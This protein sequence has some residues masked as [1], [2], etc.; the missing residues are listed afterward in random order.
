MSEE[1]LNLVERIKDVLVP[2]I[3]PI[4]KIRIGSDADGGYVIADLPVDECYSYGSNDEISFEVAMYEKYGC[5]SWTY[6]HT[7][8]GITNKPDYITFKKE[9]ISS[10]KTNDCNTLKSHLKENKSKGMLML[11]MDIEF[12]EWDVLYNINDGVLDLFDQIVIELHFF[13]L[14]MEM[15]DVIKKLQNNFTIIHLH[16]N[17]H[18]TS[19]FLD[20]ELPRVLELTLLNNRFWTTEK[21]KDTISQFPDPNLDARYEIMFNQ[22]MWWR[23]PPGLST[24][25][26]MQHSK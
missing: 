20:W 24:R 7:I 2:H 3:S 25:K 12:S 10:I 14:H 13:K 26:I 11:K 21:V 5:K 6:D 9:G 18:Q 17:P 22:H 8:D 19:P 15:P 16:A 1:W 4:N 23:R